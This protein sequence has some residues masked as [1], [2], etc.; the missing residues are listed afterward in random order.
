MDIVL[1]SPPLFLQIYKLQKPEKISGKKYGFPHCQKRFIISGNNTVQGSSIGLDLPL[2][3]LVI[4]NGKIFPIT[5]RWPLL[6]EWMKNENAFLLPR[7]YKLLLQMV[8][9]VYGPSTDC[10]PD[11]HPWQHCAVCF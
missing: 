6:A 1:Y 8:Q 5:V 11:I 10:L 9:I 4:P 7:A 2:V 3:N